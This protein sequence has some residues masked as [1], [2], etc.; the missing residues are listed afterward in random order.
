MFLVLVVSPLRAQNGGY[1]S[2]SIVGDRWINT[3]YNTTEGTDFWLTFM[4]NYGNTEDDIMA[5]C[6]LDIN[7]FMVLSGIRD[8]WVIDK[9]RLS[10]V[11]I[12]QDVS[13]I[14]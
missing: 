10:N 1:T 9:F 7:T 13:C 4:F 11:E 6:N 14:M 2:S 3:D 5:G 12:I 8:K